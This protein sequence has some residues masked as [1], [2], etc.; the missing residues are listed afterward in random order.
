MKNTLKFN[1]GVTRYWW[2]PLITGL[3]CIGMGIW[4]F[5]QPL[6]SL[7]VL[8]YIF[9]GCMCAAGLF[10][11]FY[12]LFTNGVVS[13]WGWALALGL[14]ELIAGI[15][16]FT[17]PAA[18]LTQAFIITVGVWM[19]VVC[20]NAICESAVMSAYS[21]AW[22]GWMICMLIAAVFLTIIFLGNPI[23]GATAV[24]W[25]LGISFC[26][27]GI[28]RIALACKIKKINNATDGVL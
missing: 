25:Y 5:F 1:N 7:E 14:L 27:F 4:L 24:W 28:Y 11:C 12:G 16:L 22:I 20:V 15:W 23:I 6:L 18:V 2:V 17:L 26:L 8:A 9:A 10:N 19:L 13:N 3:I 21:P